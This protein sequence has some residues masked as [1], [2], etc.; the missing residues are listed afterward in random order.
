MHQPQTDIN[1]NSMESIY[2]IVWIHTIMFGQLY[3]YISVSL[4]SGDFDQPFVPVD[5][6]E[7]EVSGLHRSWRMTKLTRYNRS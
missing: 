7:I 6:V 5:E 1:N 3:I 4:P 2:A